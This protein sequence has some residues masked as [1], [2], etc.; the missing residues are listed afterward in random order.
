MEN[1]YK[2]LNDAIC[3]LEEHLFENIDYSQ[4]SKILEMNENYS[5]IIFEL[6]T[7]Y[8]PTEYVRLRRLS[9][10]VFML[11]HQSIIEVAIAC[12]Y[13]TR[14]GFSRAFKRFHGFSP[15]QKGTY[16]PCTEYPTT[17]FHSGK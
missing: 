1:I 2:K 3:Y 9:E 5:K 8:T 13:D 4:L 6:L 11:N 12:G 17:Y 10:A 14:E 7:G 15:S 16:K